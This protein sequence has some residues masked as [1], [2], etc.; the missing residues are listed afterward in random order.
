MIIEKD[1]TTSKSSKLKDRFSYLFCLE[2]NE[3]KPQE[4]T[5]ERFIKNIA[6]YLYLKDNHPKGQEFVLLDRMQL[7]C[8][9]GLD[10]Y[11][12]EAASWYFKKFLFEKD[13]SKVPIMTALSNDRG[14][15]FIKLMMDSDFIACF[16]IRLIDANEIGDVDQARYCIIKD[17]GHGVGSLSCI[18][19]YKIIPPEK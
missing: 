2:E 1:L 17:E 12:N 15:N 5:V 3:S 11:K 18:N 6:A 4:K 16:D 14:W 19:D 10:D 9:Y 8:W 13:N 7:L